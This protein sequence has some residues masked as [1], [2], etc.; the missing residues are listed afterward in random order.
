MEV[1][2]DFAAGLGQ[3]LWEEYAYEP[4]SGQM[5]S[6]SLMDYALSRADTLPAFT[7][8]ISEVPSTSNPLGRGGEGGATPALAAV[9]NHRG[10]ARR[11]RRRA[12]RDAGDAR[13]RVGRHSGRRAPS[14]LTH[15]PLW[16]N[17]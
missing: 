1:D 12:H 17:D 16:G 3:A 10:R 9:T 15:A 13:A 4:A 2:P 8:E 11:A 7:T 14:A 6:A 5:L